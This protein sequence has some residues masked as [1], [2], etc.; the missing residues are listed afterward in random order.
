MN[1]NVSLL[2][3][4]MVA[5][6]RSDV[7]LQSRLL[8]GKAVLDRVMNRRAGS[9]KC[10]LSNLQELTRPKVV[11][12]KT[13]KSL[14]TG[15]KV[16][17]ISGPSGFSKPLEL[18]WKRG[19]VNSVFVHGTWSEP[20]WIE[21]IELHRDPSD[22]Y[23]KIDLSDRGLSPGSYI[24]KFVVD[25][26]WCIDPSLPTRPD[27]N[28]NIN[29]TIFVRSSLRP[30]KTVK[31]APTTGTFDMTSAD[32]ISTPTS[33]TALVRRIPSILNH[34]IDRRLGPVAESD[35]QESGLALICGA[36]M[37]PHPEKAN[38]GGAD[39][40]FFCP[41]G[42]GVSDGVGEWEWRFKLDPRKFAEQLMKGCLEKCAEPS[43]DWP[44]SIDRTAL[45]TLEH[46]FST[47]HAFGSA[48][49][50]VAVV[51]EPGERIGVANLGD[52][53]LIHF[54][55]QMITGNLSTT[56]VMRTK[57]QQHAFN[58][59]FQLSRIPSPHM[60]DEI[61]KDPLYEPL[62]SA[63]RTLSGR[64]LSR[65]DLPSDSDLYS[66]R[67]REGDLLILATDGVLDNLWNYDMVSL[68]AES[69]VVSPFDARLSG[70][71][72]TPPEEI[73]E[74]IALAAFEKSI[75][76]SGYKSPFGVECRKRTGAVHRGGKADDIT[77]VACWVAKKSD[78]DINQSMTC[79]D[80]WKEHGNKI[81]S[82]ST[83]EL[84]RLTT[85][86]GTD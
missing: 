83:D 18:V 80:W 28:G 42:A 1:S 50:C 47:A 7:A 4:D 49:A 16:H 74:T 20:A 25:G 15:G 29:N 27:L 34:Y 53:G 70:E 33:H 12:D 82:T 76:Q 41:T 52:S 31:S 19:A 11:H 36:W 43:E 67:I 13:L 62:I 39:S 22:G 77:V 60:Y 23:Y 75:L 59:P 78:A 44:S 79:R 55:R 5:R 85:F 69:A 2:L 61:A 45:L 17:S 14:H 32:S 8:A 10:S 54:R 24:F 73:A 57:E 35:R 6:S 63:L 65:I 51:D 58:I 9:A 56:C 84:R 86:E 21:R 38:T 40:F 68:V 3:D 26:R 37:I 66:A 64:Q 46:G 71:K 30:L 72:V 81:R 48:T